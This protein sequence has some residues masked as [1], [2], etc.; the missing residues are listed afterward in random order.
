M[1]EAP[2]DLLFLCNLELRVKSKS[3]YFRPFSMKD[4]LVVSLLI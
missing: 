4:S 3:Y 2:K 1:I